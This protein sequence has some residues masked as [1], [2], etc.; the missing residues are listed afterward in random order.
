MHIEEEEKEKKWLNAC[1][2]SNIY[3]F[4][5]VLKK[6]LNKIFI[7]RCILYIYSIINKSF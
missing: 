5:L 6:I 7:Y 1:F 3:L 4:L 2:Y